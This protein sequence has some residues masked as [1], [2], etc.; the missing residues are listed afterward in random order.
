M[1][2]RFINMLHVEQGQ[3]LDELLAAAPS[4]PEVPPQTLA[5]FLFRYVIETP[6][7]I[8]TSVSIA[9]EDQSGSAA[10]VLDIDCSAQRDFST[11]ASGMNEIRRMLER[12]KV[13]KNTVFF[14]SIAEEALT[15]WQSR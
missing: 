12:L 15:R 10:L 13:S 5:A 9:M 6:D 4:V 11:A 7:G 1:A 14:A 2:T 3:P 8:T